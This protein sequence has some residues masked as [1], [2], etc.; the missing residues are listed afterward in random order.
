MLMNIVSSYLGLQQWRVVGT[1]AEQLQ[2]P[3]ASYVEESAVRGGSELLQTGAVLQRTAGLLQP[4]LHV[5]GR[6]WLSPVCV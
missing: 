6:P 3:V 5:G 2:R 1:A 4:L